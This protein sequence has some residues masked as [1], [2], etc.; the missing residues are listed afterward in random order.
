MGAGAVASGRLAGLVIFPVVGEGDAWLG[1]FGRD[2]TGNG[3]MKHRYSK[4]MRRA[5]L[6]WNSAALYAETDAPLFVCEGVLDAAPLWPD[7][8]ACLG[9]PLE[10]HIEL[11]QG[12]HRPIVCCLDGDAWEESWMLSLKL[13]FMGKRSGFIKLA[14]KQ[15]PNDVPAEW[16][17]E[18]GAKCML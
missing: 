6:V 16:L 8:I 12:C 5:D 2:A 18:Q 7:G 15:D 11:L 3:R 14:P 4:G 13:K 10:G 9:K 1:W 17:R